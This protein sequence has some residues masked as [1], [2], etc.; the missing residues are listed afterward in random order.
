MVKNS[1]IRRTAVLLVPALIA[2]NILSAADQK[3][4]SQG[5]SE[6]GVDIEVSLAYPSTGSNFY[7]QILHKL[8]S[9]GLRIVKSTE[10]QDEIEPL[11]TSNFYGRIALNVLM[12]WTWHM[13]PFWVADGDYAAIKKGN[14]IILVKGGTDV[15]YQPLKNTTMIGKFN[16]NTESY[17]KKFERHTWVIVPE[18]H[19]G[20]AQKARNTLVLEQGYHHLKD[21]EQFKETINLGELLDKNDG[22][23]TW[24]NIGQTTDFVFLNVALKNP[25]DKIIIRDRENAPQVLGSGWYLFSK[26]NIVPFESQILYKH[27]STK[28]NAV[29]IAD[30][31]IEFVQHFS[32]TFP[33]E[34]LYLKLIQGKESR[35]LTYAQ[36]AAKF[37]DQYDDIIDHVKEKI[38]SAILQENFAY[39]SDDLDIK[40]AKKQTLKNAKEAI[41][42]DSY[43]KGFVGIKVVADYVEISRRKVLTHFDNLRKEK[44]KTQVRNIVRERERE[45]ARLEHHIAMGKTAA[46]ILI[47]ANNKPKNLYTI[48]KAKIKADVNEQSSNTKKMALK[49]LQTTDFNGDIVVDDDGEGYSDEDLSDS[50]S[51]GS[52]SSDSNS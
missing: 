3:R 51:D 29:C 41:E 20:I 48:K 35:S 18:G 13:H 36:S 7:G 6:R 52:D 10:Y 42:D 17:L 30:S 4:A 21:G 27:Q 1:L 26:K 49:I 45:D 5:P 22:E 19:I 2:A 31:D 47:N 9:Q 15:R 24:K 25:D 11:D 28:T 16:E 32:V 40:R 46:K 37:V 50:S 43:L 38:A 33:S 8:Q 34:K 39:D 12:F 14:R 23:V 44:N